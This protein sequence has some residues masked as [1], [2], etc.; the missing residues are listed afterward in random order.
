MHGYRLMVIR[1][2]AVG[3]YRI[4]QNFFTHADPQKREIGR[5]Q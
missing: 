3:K 5:N 2:C 4:E 1:V